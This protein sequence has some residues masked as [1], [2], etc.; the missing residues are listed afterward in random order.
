M[1]KIG[2]L[3]ICADLCISAY[4]HVET[5]STIMRR[6]QRRG[7]TSD[8]D[9][10]IVNAVLIT[11][12]LTFQI[13]ALITLVRTLR[14][15]VNRKRAGGIAFPTLLFKLLLQESTRLSRRDHL[16]SMVVSSPIMAT[17]EILILMKSGVF[18]LIT[19]KL[20]FGTDSSYLRHDEWLPSKAFSLSSTPPP[21]CE[22]D[23]GADAP[24]NDYAKDD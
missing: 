2:I 4:D 22:Y 11:L 6:Q 21:P 23:T 5:L 14:G 19:G 15:R 7:G 13:V 20:A 12:D 8:D 16:P 24:E 17:K 9:V 18:L 3:S 10:G 1:C